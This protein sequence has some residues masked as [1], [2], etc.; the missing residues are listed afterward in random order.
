MNMEGS[1]RIYFRILAEHEIVR[2]YLIINSFDGALTILG[3]IFAEFFGSVHDP[4]LIILPGI[5][6]AVAM[7]VS[8]VW[9][10]YSAER[11]EVKHAIRTMEAH[12]LKDLSGTEFSR[13]REHMA[14][15]VGLVDGISP[16]AASFFILMPFFFVGAGAIPINIAYQISFALVGIVL[17]TLGALAGRIARESMVKHGIIML[18]AGGTIGA[19]FLLLAAAGAL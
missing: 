18:L 14:F 8:G 4:A 3:I 15:V 10:A 17:F 2:R 19:I 12:L 5:G 13:K 11:A 1:L 6:A 9:G 7:C 16:L